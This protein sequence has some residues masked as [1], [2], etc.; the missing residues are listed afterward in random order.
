MRKSSQTGRHL[1]AVRAAALLVAASMGSGEPL[2]SFESP[3][4]EE[5]V[6]EAYFLGQRH[7]ESVSRALE[8][9]T[10]YFA[11]PAYGP[12]IAWVTY[13]T[14]FALA[15]LASSNHTGNYSAQQAQI[16]HRRQP[17]TVEIQV[18]IRFTDSYPALVPAAG[19]RR[20]PAGLVPRPSDF[21]R[22]FEITV[23]DGEKMLEPASLEG[24]PDYTCN[25]SS[26]FLI[27]ATVLI[28][29]AA[30]DFAKQD[31]A[32]EVDPPAGERLVSNLDLSALR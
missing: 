4:S 26:C 25:E 19:S 23:F 3:L 7:D 14:P 17:E 18:A 16:D 1:P 2:F 28:T 20:G 12:Q 32:V 5:A 9:Y 24:R 6:R 8:K 10:Q 30:A 27:G 31:V 22:D 13:L 21:W 29:F 15:V 11:T